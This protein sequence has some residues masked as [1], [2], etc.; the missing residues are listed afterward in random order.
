VPV[1]LQ[2]KKREI[3]PT[4]CLALSF[5]IRHSPLSK[6]ISRFLFS[7]FDQNFGILKINH[8]WGISAKMRMDL[9]ER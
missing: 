7:L 4:L 3:G 8:S 9:N 5:G 2:R 1:F 6:I